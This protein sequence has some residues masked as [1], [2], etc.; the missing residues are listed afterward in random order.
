MAG[1]ADSDAFGDGI[2]NTEQ[3]ANR[4]CENIAQYTGN[5]DGSHCDGHVAPQLFHH[6]DA[7]GS[8]DGFGQH[9]HKGGPAEMKEAGK[10]QHRNHGDNDAGRN[11][12]HY[13]PE[14]LL[15]G[16]QLPVQGYGQADGGWGH[17]VTD[18]L[19]AVVIG[20]VINVQQF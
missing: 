14:I 6:A 18:V 1:A 20:C 10:E 12:Q 7:E 2:F 11:S 13:S 16:I 3:L 15:Q 4:L 8:G 17:Q 9:G 5:D 19:R